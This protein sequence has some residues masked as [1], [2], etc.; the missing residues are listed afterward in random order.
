L[1]SS[2]SNVQIIARV[3]F[4][5]F[6]LLYTDY[7]TPD[8]VTTIVTRIIHQ[9]SNPLMV[10]DDN[11]FSNIYIGICFYPEDGIQPQLLMKNAGLALDSAKLNEP[12]SFAF[13]S[14]EMDALIA[15]RRKLIHELRDAFDKDQFELY[16]QAQVSLQESDKL[17]GVEA[18][19]R[20]MHPEKGMISPVV[21]IPI[22]EQTGMIIQL[23]YWI[24][25][26]A[27]QQAKLWSEA[28]NP[29]R[30]AVNLS[31]IQFMQKDLFINFKKIIEEINV[32]PKLIELEITESVMMGDIDET[33]SKI[34]NFVDMGFIIALDDFGTGYSSLSYLRKLPIHKI[35]IDQSFV[36]DINKSDDAKDIIRC[37]V[38]MAKGLRLD[39]IA[40]GIEDQDQK[41]F[42]KDLE[43][44]EGQ[45]Y[46][47][48]KPISAA[49]LE[50]KYL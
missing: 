44:N 35:K 30:I 32:S 23:G 36:R 7:N 45:G 46:L 28:G 15:E 50:E 49:E 16:Y 12:N 42:L 40:E 18:L 34:Q 37:I 31:S 10:Q 27:C 25:K 26:T 14:R 47:F 5:Q 11:I 43:V 9:F 6:M 21:F 22:V 33:I 29:L 48:S 24:F 17:I 2:L 4:N 20:W 8:D 1:T 3:G 41:N 38:G 13:Y 39:T 19:I